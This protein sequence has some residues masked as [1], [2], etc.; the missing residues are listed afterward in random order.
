MKEIWKD[1]P[2]Y[3]GKYKVSN[4]GGVR[5]L[6][7]RVRILKTSR[8]KDGYLRVGLSK[9]GNARRF[10][11]HQLVAMAFLNHKP[12]GNKLVVNHKNFVK[13]DNRLENLE[14]VTNRENCNKKHLY[15]TSKYTG[16]YWD[17][18]RKIWRAEITIKGKKLYLGSFED[19]YN[20]HIVYERALA[21]I[22][23]FS[24]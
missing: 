19:D 6:G 23:K 9:N 10:K 24:E 7:A 20:A 12:K 4:L 16:V 5:S 15:S 13:S 18:R 17:K 11:V 8:T 1:I 22:N 21:E 14:V 3:F 2:G